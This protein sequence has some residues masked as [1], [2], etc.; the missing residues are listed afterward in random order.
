MSSTWSA[1]RISAWARRS[2][3]TSPTHS[4][5][6][7]AQWNIVSPES[8]L[9]NVG[10]DGFIAQVWTG[11]ARTPN[12]YEGRK[13]QR[14]FET[15]FLEY[16][17]M[18]DVVR[19]A[20]G[21]VWFLNDPIE[22]NPD[23]S[24]LDYR[25]NW[26]STLVASLLWPGVHKYEVMPWPERIWR[27]RYPTVDRANRKPG[28]PVVKEPIPPGYA[29][30]LLTVINTL[31]DMDQPE[32][33]WDCGT[34]GI[35]VVV[36]DSMMFQRGG[37]S[38]SDPDLGSFYGLA[39]PLLKRG[40]PVEPAQLE[41]ATR[42]GALDRHKVLLLTFEGMKP[43]T[44]EVLTALAEWTKRGGVLVFIDDDTDPFNH[45]QSWWNDPALHF[46]NMIPR[47]HL[48]R[49][50]GLDPAIPAGNHPVGSGQLVFDRLSPAAL[51]HRADGGEYVRAL[52]QRAVKAAHL[53]WRETNHLVLRRGPYVV[54]AGLDESAAEPPLTLRGRFVDLFDPNLLI[55]TT[56]ELIPGARRFLLDLDR[57]KDPA[58]P[59]VLAAAAKVFEPRVE[60]DRFTFIAE[61]PSR[62]NAA[63]RVRLPVRPL[64]VRVVGINPDPGSTWDEATRTLLIQFPHDPSGRRVTIDLN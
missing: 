50:L 11:T 24:W 48:F 63:I 19:G 38:P 10:A 45:V 28:E 37:P 58:T 25:T 47:H 60:G 55:L 30:E 42:P 29:T 53:D 54:A 64:G 12:V 56:V 2:S 36:S 6:N 13:Q 57:I 59:Q 7:Y 8:S 35:G 31:N 17:S 34:R 21:T 9:L 32:V 23:H 49:A 52:A 22:D 5:I 43:Q 18:G 62:T 14:T 4:L 33:A 1:R 27:G 44:L 15:A 41:N 26:E 39:M 16:G 20:G 51:S 61:G 3:A 46:N 40:M